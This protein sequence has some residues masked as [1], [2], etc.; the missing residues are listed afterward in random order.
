MKIITK[1]SEYFKKIKGEID[2]LFD[3]INKNISENNQK[4]SG[5]ME[6]NPK[7]FKDLTVLNRILES[8]FQ[9]DFL[10]KYC[11]FELSSECLDIIQTE[12]GDWNQPNAG[13]NIT[14]LNIPY[15]LVR[16]LL[17]VNTWELCG[18]IK[19]FLDRFNNKPLLH[20][21]EYK[22]NQIKY[23]DWEECTEKTKI[24]NDIIF[25]AWSI[26]ISIDNDS[27]LLCGGKQLNLQK[28]NENWAKVYKINLKSQSF[29]SLASM[30]TGRKNFSMVYMDGF[31]YSLG[32]WD[33]LDEIIAKCER[34]SLK[35]D[36][37]ENISDLNNPLHLATCVSVSK[38]NCIYLIGGLN[39]FNRL[40]E[41]IEK[42][43]AKVN[44]WFIIK[45][46]K[47]ILSFLLGSCLLPDSNLILIYGG[48]NL[49]NESQNE[50][51]LYDYK[52]NQI[53]ETDPML[54]VYNDTT[55][56]PVVYDNKIYS[57]LS[58]INTQLRVISIYDIESR[59]WSI[60]YQDISNSK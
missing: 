28:T 52:T 22:T 53:T 3:F 50:C 27:L 15:K 56:I 47:P 9:S 38:E 33:Y 60:L 51:Y 49:K 25:P 13:K 46:K 55:D 18:E 8:N 39:N 34:Y 7:T 17:N 43:E 19:R 11:E 5:L 1:I 54:G 29:Q 12:I 30:N 16:E 40:N 32:G 4:L 2:N 24:I 44:R 58:K 23:F 59:D 45:I 37:W 26:S 41:N 21:C 48:R 14:K 42:Y 31:Y 10:T 36:R 6:D 35:N 57:Y 20:W